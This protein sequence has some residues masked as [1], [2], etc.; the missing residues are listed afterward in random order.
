VLKDV[1]EITE[2]GERKASSAVIRG[3]AVEYISP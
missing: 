2:S 3:A 1:E